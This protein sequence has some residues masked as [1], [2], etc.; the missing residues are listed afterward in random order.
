MICRKGDVIK[1]DTRGGEIRT[2]T[3]TDVN[4]NIYWVWYYE[5]KVRK[6]IASHIDGRQ[7]IEVV[8]MA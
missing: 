4:R 6:E 3:V 8:Q 7:I 2:G 1:F 5:E